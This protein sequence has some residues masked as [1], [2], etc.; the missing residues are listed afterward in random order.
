ML[1]VTGLMLLSESYFGV[2]LNTIIVFLF[3]VFTCLI[4]YKIIFL[5]LGSK[6]SWILGG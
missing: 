5:L 6:R 1:N 2:L 3:V 4:I